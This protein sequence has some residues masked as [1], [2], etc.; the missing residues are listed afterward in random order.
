MVMGTIPYMSPEQVCGETVD[1]RTDIFSLGV[2]LY[3][4]TTGRRPFGGKNPAET[5]SS[6]LRDAPR[7]VTEARLDVP[8]HLG[9]I[10]DH[11]LKPAVDLTRDDSY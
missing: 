5:I 4:L 2:V 10:I 8:R 1:A 6:I 9:R 7:P 3:E 11:C